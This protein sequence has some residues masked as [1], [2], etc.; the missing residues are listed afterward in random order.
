M[1]DDST[2]R[3]PSPPM[4]NPEDCRPAGTVII[5]PIM[6][7]RNFLATPL[8]GFQLAASAPEKPLYASGDG[9]PHTPEEYAELLAGLAKSGDLAPDQYSRGG[10]VQKLE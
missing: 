2:T 9:I 6:R 10:V 8:A 1:K 3:R 4:G 7:R 5:P